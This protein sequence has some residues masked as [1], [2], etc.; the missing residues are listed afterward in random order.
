[1][2]KYVKFI[3]ILLVFILCLSLVACKDT[4]NENETTLEIVPQTN[5]EKDLVFEPN[6]DGN[7]Y[8]VFYYAGKDKN[9]VIPKTYS[10]RLVTSIDYQAFLK[11]LSADERKLV[12]L[13]MKGKNTTE[14]ASILGLKTHSAVV[15]RLQKIQEKYRLWFGGTDI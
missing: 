3:T 12:A 13:R 1:M 2:K 9:V 8:K 4:N 7:T 14:I 15:K 11:R 10:G 6:I 5:P